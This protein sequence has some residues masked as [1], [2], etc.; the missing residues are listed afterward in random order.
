MTCQFLIG[1]FN[2][3]YDIIGQNDARMAFILP[4]ALYFFG[5]GAIVPHLSIS[6][7]HFSVL[8]RLSLLFLSLSLCSFTTSRV[9]SDLELGLG[10]L[11]RDDGRQADC[12]ATC[13]GT[14]RLPRISTTR[15]GSGSSLSLSVGLIF[16]L[17][18]HH[19]CTEFSFLWCFFSCFMSRLMSLS[20]G[21]GSCL[22]RMITKVLLPD[23]IDELVRLLIWSW[24][25][26]ISCFCM[27]IFC[28]DHSGHCYKS[29]LLLDLESDDL[30]KNCLCALL[31]EWLVFEISNEMT[32][33]QVRSVLAVVV[34]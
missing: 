18:F 25:M 29:S 30:F 1:S 9:L 21:G 22:T 6:A 23:L 26:G 5:K 16:V 14:D 7:V 34:Q 12:P 19:D 28:S 3:D 13:S 10:F 32:N 31:F 8:L 4:S 33:K 11:S 27:R 24:K 17:I 2:V 20:K 15:F